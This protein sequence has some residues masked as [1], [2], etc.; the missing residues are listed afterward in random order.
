MRLDTKFSDIN[1]YAC[2]A[3]GF[4]SDGGGKGF[5]SFDVYPPIKNILSGVS[6]NEF[7]V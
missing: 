4:H 1:F 7:E 2:S 5:N 3:L 6:K